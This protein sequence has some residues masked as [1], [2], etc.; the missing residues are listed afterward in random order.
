[1]KTT[2]FLFV[3]TVS[4]GAARAQD[5]DYSDYSNETPADYQVPAVVYNAPVIYSA[6]VVYDIPVI[7][8]APVYYGQMMAMGSALN[9]CASACNDFSYRARSTVTFIGGGHVSYLVSPP[10][11][12]GS[13]LVFIGSSWFH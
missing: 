12:T 2:L 4:L 7:Y 10:C 5:A 1:M 13:T 8:N 6:P 3:L 11:N 9:A